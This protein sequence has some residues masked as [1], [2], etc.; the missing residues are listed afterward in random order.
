MCVT[1]SLEGGGAKAGGIMTK[2]F[3]MAAPMARVANIA[4]TRYSGKIS[5]LAGSQFCQLC[6][7]RSCFVNRVYAS[8]NYHV[9]SVNS[10]RK[11][12]K[13][14]SKVESQ[15]RKCRIRI[16]NLFQL[17]IQVQSKSICY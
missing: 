2:H 13:K 6:C 17:E 11:R 5:T 14:Q 12:K 3:K 7:T 8:A 15:L 10:Q 16:F 1:F 9:S 4:L